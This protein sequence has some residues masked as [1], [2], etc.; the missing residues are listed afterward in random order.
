MTPFLHSRV[1]PRW[2]LSGGALAARSTTALQPARSER[3]V[4]GLPAHGV[5]RAVDAGERRARV[6]MCQITL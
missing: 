4:L 2:E 5:V 1:S 6:E 3:D